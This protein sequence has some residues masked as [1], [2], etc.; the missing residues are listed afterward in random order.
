MLVFDTRAPSD[1]TAHFVILARQDEH[2]AAIRDFLFA[3]RAL[4]DADWIR[5][6]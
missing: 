3:P 2:I 1:R 4:K 5:L 6:G